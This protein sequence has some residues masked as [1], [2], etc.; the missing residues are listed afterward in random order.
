MTDP[1]PRRSLAPAWS[2]WRSTAGRSRWPTTA[3]P[4]SRPCATA[5]GPDRPR[6]AAARRASAGA[7]RC[8]STAQPRVACVTPACAG[9]RP[10]R[11]PPSTGS[12][13][14]RAQRGPTPSPPPGPASAGSARRGSSCRLAALAPARRGRRRR[15]ASTGRCP[16]TSAAAPAGRPILEAAWCRVDPARSRGP[17]R[18][19]RRPPP[20]GPAIEGR[21]AAGVGPDV[22]LGRGGFADDS[23]PADALVAVP[24]GRGGWV[25]GETLAEARRLAGKVPGPP[26]HR[27]RPTSPAR[28]ARRRLGRT[29]RTTWVEPGLPRDRRRR[30]ARPGGEPASRSPTAAPSAASVVAGGRRRPPT[31]RRAR[32]AGAGRCSPG[33]TSSASGPSGRRS[34]AGSTPTAAGV[35]PDRAAPPGIAAAV[36]AVAPDLVGRGG[37]RPRPAD[38]MPRLRGAGW[39]EAAVLLA[40]AGRRP[41]R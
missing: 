11:S 4:C 23:A 17:P 36:A 32:P 20:D 38:V 5:W 1:R 16:P 2:G 34:P 26:H 6:T 14:R 10:R 8:W 18:R 31:R 39:A 15:P 30:G 22:A 29:L 37:R 12:T 9:G 27:R 35:A 19:S 21:A 3:S 25:V 24:D 41:A 33:R 13:R 7:A 28:P 40:V